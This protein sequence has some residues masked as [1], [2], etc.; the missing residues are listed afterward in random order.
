MSANFAVRLCSLLLLIGG[1]AAQ[2]YAAETPITLDT[3]TGQLAGTL[4]L[5]AGADKPR[6]ALLIAGSGPTDRDGNSSMI[7]GRNDSLKLLAAG[8]ADA[9]IA[10]VRYDK[11]GIGGSHAAGSAESALRFEMFVDDAA[12]WIARLKA[13][14][15]FASVAVIGHSEGSLIGMLAARQTDAAAFVSIAG[16]ADGASTLMRKQL[17]GK[18][19]PELE[20]ES[21]RILVSLESGVVVDPVPPA[22][23]T[24][25]RPSVQPYL[26]SWFK[27]V[28][29]QRIAELTM[30]VLIVQGNTD[31]QVDVV[32][33]NRLHGARPGAKLAIIPGMNHV[34][35]HVR[36]VPELQVASYGDPSLPVSPLLVKS[37]ADFLQQGGA[38]AP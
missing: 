4:E 11:R 31:I 20:K 9:G 16:I 29:A 12:A 2:A 1:I 23:A 33:A 37:I 26:I 14:P 35:K 8:L 15:R 7:P 22:L 5:P 3:P 13:D 30:P 36:A 21:E 28:P 27:Y 6:V 24:L 38:T 34:F 18:L 25:F 17:E 32:Q 19:P 10:T